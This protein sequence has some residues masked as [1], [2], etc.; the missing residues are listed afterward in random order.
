MHDTLR[1]QSP[2]PGYRLH[3]LEVSNW[4]TFDS[5]RG[6]V[7]VVSPAGAT[8]LLIGQNASGKSTLV[9]ALLTLLVRPVVRNYN[10]AAGSGKQERDER[11][12]ITGAC[13]RASREEDNRAEM[14]FLRPEGRQPAI[15]LASFRNNRSEC[16]TLVQVLYLNQEGGTEKIY[17]FAEDER[18]IVKDCGGLA[19]ERVRHQ[20][21]KRGFR[22]TEKYVE[23]HGWMTKRTG[24]RPKAM[25]MLNQTVAVK[26]IKSL[27]EFIRDH[28]LESQ[29]WGARIE[30]LQ[31]HFAILT[32][33]HD[34]LVRIRR[35]FELLQP[36][37]AKGEEYRNHAKDLVRAEAIWRASES[38]F[39][40]KTIDLLGPFVASIRSELTAASE[41]KGRLDND[42]SRTSD[43]ARRL[44]N[45]IEQAGGERLREIPLLIAN[46]ESEARAKRERNQRF[47]SALSLHRNLQHN[48]TD[49]TSLQA[50]HSSL[51]QFNQSLAA[52]G[53]V[54]KQERDRKLLEHGQTNAQ[55]LQRI[56]ESFRRLS[57]RQSKLPEG[58]AEVRWRLCART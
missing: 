39:R 54:I 44:Q 25:D 20:M 56:G 31:T 14:Q 35:Q 18:S 48:V 42:M 3:K 50:L 15:L 30:Q 49:A 28:M 51:P 58:H 9:D 8:T 26:D 24:M 10:V 7:H 19:A 27:D 41:A 29:P 17:C 53:Q 33:A 40:Q 36:I 57:N 5:S 21:E 13:G 46:H 16:F 12:Y 1:G 52:S 43:E 38:Y 55:S 32:E 22:A 37:A 47:Q 6:N 23:Y 34:G 4:G 45:E 2:T 11:T